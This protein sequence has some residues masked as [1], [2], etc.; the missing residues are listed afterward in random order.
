MLKIRKKLVTITIFLMLTINSSILYA[1]GIPVFQYNQ[2]ISYSSGGRYV[3]VSPYNTGSSTSWYYNDVDGQYYGIT[4]YYLDLWTSQSYI[5][6]DY[7]ISRV[8]V[9]AW[10]QST[11][12]S[13]GYFYVQYT[14]DGVNWSSA[15]LTGLPSGGG[16]LSTTITIPSSK[17][18]KMGLAASGQTNF[19]NY[20][21][22]SVTNLEMSLAGADQG[23]VEAAKNAAN[24]ASSYAQQASTNASNAYN[25]A[26]SASTY[27]QQAKTSA[28]TAAANASNAY[29][30]VSNVNGNTV[31]AVRDVD[32][33]VL[34][35][36]RQASAKLD[37]MQTSIS[38]I[39]N[40][41]GADTTP[42]SVKLRTVSGA[43]A[44]SGAT[45]QAVLD[46]S[47]NTNSSFTYSLDGAAYA[48]VPV[49]RI[50]FLPVNTPGPNTIPVWVKDQAGNVGMAS[51]TIR[52]L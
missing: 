36:A 2:S 42:P 52:K 16:V 44:T 37:T 7:Y 20:G 45:I 35:V 39:Q 5:G 43:M 11:Y 28:D 23:T 38:N 6:T 22:V 17:Q 31:T 49:N 32:G 21:S 1:D 10:Q 3:G 40:S 12:Y 15:S 9:S 13:S 18:I 24:N 50:I 30:A 51:I 19:I 27:A 29:N 46:I 47:D 41:I 25:A 4:T 48:A 33:T 26:S 14:T 34:G 8:S